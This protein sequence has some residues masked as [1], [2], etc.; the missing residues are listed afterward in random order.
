MSGM[1]A[2]LTSR[3]SFKFRDVDMHTPAMLNLCVS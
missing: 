1:S 3:R 2:L